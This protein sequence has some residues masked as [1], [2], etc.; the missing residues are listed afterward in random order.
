MVKI[1]FNTE[2]LAIQSTNGLIFMSRSR[3]RQRNLGELLPCKG[4]L[5]CVISNINLLQP[6]KFQ[7]DTLIILVFC[8]VFVGMG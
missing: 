8:A 6:H 4:E 5:F 1:K 7:I 2:Q 3:W